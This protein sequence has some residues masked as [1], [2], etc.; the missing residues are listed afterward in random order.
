MTNYALISVKW[1]KLLKKQQYLSNL[2]VKFWSKNYW[3]FVDCVSGFGRFPDIH[4]E[5]VNFTY[6]FAYTYTSMMMFK[7]SRNPHFSIFNPAKVHHFKY[8]YRYRD[9]LYFFYRYWYRGRIKNTSN[10]CMG[11]F[12]K[13]MQFLRCAQEMALYP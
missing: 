8:I 9:H 10:M 13:W 12:L 1:W 2:T 6:I 4:I 11:G 5:N 3:K 7:T